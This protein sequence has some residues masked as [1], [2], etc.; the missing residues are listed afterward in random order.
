MD[1]N[2]FAP[3]NDL[4]YGLA[5]FNILLN[6]V[7]QGHKISWF[8]IGQ[9]RA[10]SKYHPLLKE[11]VTNAQMFNP[12]APCVRVYHQNLLAERVG[13]GSAFGFPF[14]ELDTF[15]DVERHHLQSVDG[16]IVASKW[17]RD[18]LSQNGVSTP[19]WVVP[20]GVDTE[21]FSPDTG[22]VVPHK[23]TVFFTC[24]KYEIRKGHDF[25]C[26]AFNKAFT[27]GDNVKL[28]LNCE[29]PFIG[30]QKNREWAEY[31]KKS[32]LGDKVIVIEK[33]LQSQHEVA[34]IMRQVDCGVFLAR[35]EGWNLEALEMLACGKDIIITNYSGHTEFA[36]NTN[37]LLV[38][39]TDLEPAN[40]G[41]FFHG[42]G[43]WLALGDWQMEQTVV[44]MRNV[45]HRKQDGN[46]GLNVAGLD[47]AKRFSWS[48]TAA[49][50]TKVL[51]EFRS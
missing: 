42:Q 41:V 12:D 46:L 3:V 28:V 6:L 25:L 13:R 17:A 8:P 20:L 10:D 19:A 16:I 38:G 27:P 33:R 37:S 23:E 26:E 7:K 49:L 14:Y 35:A 9:T 40:D 29:N 44:H 30:E 1:I 2:F 43:N 50:L 51:S 15:T 45:H 48:Q 36:T 21:I 4:G 22:Y 24:G 5:A 11:C 18:I 32:D 47:T 34:S 31:Y 39:G